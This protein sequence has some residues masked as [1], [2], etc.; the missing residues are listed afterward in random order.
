MSVLDNFDKTDDD[1]NM[2][3]KFKLLPETK[4][5]ELRI[6]RL[7]NVPADRLGRE[8]AICLQKVVLPAEVP[9]RHIFCQPCLEPVRTAGGLCPECRGTL[10]FSVDLKQ[11]ARQQVRQELQRLGLEDLLLGEP[12]VIKS[13]CG[14]HM[15]KWQNDE[16]GVPTCIEHELSQ[17][18]AVKVRLEFNRPATTAESSLIEGAVRRRAERGGEAEETV[19]IINVTSL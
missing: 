3:E 11:Q 4:K 6:R 10:T 19:E 13:Y 14:L 15:F 12:D 5:R 16:E 18:N 9:C 7:L 17:K 2:P 8:C 1:V